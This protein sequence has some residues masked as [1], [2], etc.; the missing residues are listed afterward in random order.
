MISTVAAGG[1]EGRRVHQSMEPQSLAAYEP[2]AEEVNRQ[3][4]RSEVLI[5]TLQVSIGGH[6]SPSFKARLQVNRDDRPGHMPGQT[7]LGHLTSI[8]HLNTT[9]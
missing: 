8:Q 1:W 6:L 7:S 9:L 5:S 2:G 4:W 3:E